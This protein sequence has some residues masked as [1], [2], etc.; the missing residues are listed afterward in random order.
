VKLHSAN[1]FYQLEGCISLGA[2]L[3]DMNDDGYNDVTSSNNTMKAFHRVMGK[4]T[5][6]LFIVTNK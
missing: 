1:Y 4:D 6:A 5:E 2:S 3:L